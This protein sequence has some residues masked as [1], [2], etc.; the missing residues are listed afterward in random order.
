MKASQFRTPMEV[1]RIVEEAVTQNPM[2]KELLRLMYEPNHKFHIKVS[3]E[4]YNLTAD[5]V[6]TADDLTDNELL[7]L[8]YRLSDREW[9]RNQAS[10]E[11]WKFINTRSNILV[12][13]LRKTLDNGFGM[14]GARDLGIIQTHQPQKGVAVKDIATLPY[15]CHAERKYNGSRLTVFCYDDG[16]VVCKLLKGNI[17]KID[18]LEDWFRRHG[19]A[20]R[21]YDG[22][23]VYG[24]GITEADRV[25][26]AGQITSATSTK[27]NLPRVELMPNPVPL[28]FVVY[29]TTSVPEFETATSPVNTFSMRRNELLVW[30]QAL[31]GA[32]MVSLSEAWTVENV[33]QMTYLLKMIKEQNGEGVMVKPMNGTYDFKKNKQWLKVKLYNE[34]DM[35]IV[36]YKPHKKYASWIGSYQL[37]GVVDGKTVECWC[38]SGLN[39]I[40][41]Q[42]NPATM[43][44]AIVQVVYLDLLQN[45]DGWSMANPRFYKARPEDSLSGY[46]RTDTDAVNN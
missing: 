21:A 1:R 30:Y 38:G 15:P 11:V 40:D 27:S 29:D 41:R 34:A 5:N 20:G 45:Q 16:S 4:E 8:L 35:Q 28:S 6:S 12:L 13:F 14:G 39:D 26:L 23:L 18:W 24:D 25:A 22:E 10:D 36:G 7:I 37:R 17:I 9:G 44:G 33:E 32:G 3:H 46:V 19:V 43:Q 42:A 2:A 31:G